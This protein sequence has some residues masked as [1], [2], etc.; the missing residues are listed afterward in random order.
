MLTW[1]SVAMAIVASYLSSK[2]NPNMRLVFILYFWSNLINIGYFLI[3]QQPEYLF[4]NIMYLLNSINGL[5]NNGQE[6]QKEKD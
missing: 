5:R 4:M 6:I 1:I 3:T 2:N